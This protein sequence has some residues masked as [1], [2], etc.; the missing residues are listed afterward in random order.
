ML[1]RVSTAITLASTVAATALLAAVL[2]N[3][4][5]SAVWSYLALGLVISMQVVLLILVV[6]T[7]HRYLDKLTMPELNDLQQAK[8]DFEEDQVRIRREIEAETARLEQMS[9][10]VAD[11]FRVI[12][13]WLDTPELIDLRDSRS[14]PLETQFAASHSMSHVDRD[15]LAE[16]DRK[17]AQILETQA[18]TIYEKIRTNYYAPA[19]KFDLHLFREDMMTLAI[20]IAQVYKPGLDNPLLR[21][22]PEQLA[23]ALNRIGLHLLVVM[24]QLPIDLKS[25]DIQTTYDTVRKAI[26]TYGHY[27]K[28]S[29]YLDWASKGIFFGRMVTS[30]NP[31]TLGIWW[32]ATELGKFGARKFASRII[33]RQAVGL[34]QSLVRVV[35]YEVAAIYGGDFRH[36]DPNW[37]YGVEISQMVGMLPTSRASL[38]FALKEITRLELRNEYDRLTLFRAVSAG[39]AIGRSHV[40]VDMLTEEERRRILELLEHAYQEFSHGRSSKESDQWRKSV[41][42]HLGLQFSLKTGS[43]QKTK[44]RDLVQDRE[45]LRC[46]IAF[47]FHVKQLSVTEIRVRLEDIK[48][49]EQLQMQ[50]APSECQ[51]LVQ[52]LLPAEL[53][54]PGWELMPPD[55]DP[56]DRRVAAML[57]LLTSW[58]ASIPPHSPEAEGVLVE[59]GLYYRR[60]LRDMEEKVCEA[61]QSFLEETFPA[62]AERIGHFSPLESRAVEY[63]KENSQ[64][65]G[66]PD[67]IYGRVTVA[68][69]FFNDALQTPGHKDDELRIFVVGEQ[70]V[71]VDLGGLDN[72]P[73]IIWQATPETILENQSSVMTAMALLRNGKTLAEPGAAE[74][75]AVRIEA[76]ITAR[77][78]SF[79]AALMRRF[80]TT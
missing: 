12:H 70:I 58:N 37:A 13:E 5:V 10:K 20:Q 40:Y 7:R 29:P 59:L 28:A 24:D 11:R 50:I 57:D 53:N 49:C 45:V 51:Q 8:R 46:V 41:Q 64:L 36:R 66:L 22:T 21:T 47:L 17:V 73:E 9:R 48:I 31:L 6:R 71:L 15:R 56:D 32:G 34:L 80:A 19:Q 63:L 69:R 52:E 33:D 75:T 77:Y 55:L 1:F 23:R 16:H 78:Q 68:W 67:Q 54:K 25:Y 39:K 65:S 30:V 76:P 35:G 27:T 42:E 74:I 72:V 18:E 61:Y 62:E 2:L 43:G 3:D 26:K 4:S 44:S 60:P 38:Q 14:E 79:F